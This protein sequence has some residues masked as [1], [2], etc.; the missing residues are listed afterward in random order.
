MGDW[1]ERGREHAQVADPAATKGR[2]DSLHSLR[3]DAT[4]GSWADE[5]LVV[6]QQDDC[7]EAK[8]EAPSVTLDSGLSMNEH[9]S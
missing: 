1:T 6:W 9:A 3:S 8:R 4:A 7:A 5:P 2:E